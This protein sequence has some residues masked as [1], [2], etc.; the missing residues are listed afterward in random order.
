M[1][2]ERNIL[3]TYFE[4]G[5]FPTESQFAQLIDSYAHL[6]EFNFSLKAKP[7][8]ISKGKFYH[9]HVANNIK[10][11]GAGHKIIEAPSGSTPNSINGYT[12]VL[13]RNV[14]YK[15][16]DV[17][18][19][20]GIDVEKHKPMIIIERYKQRKKLRSGYV[21][22][23]GFYKERLEDAQLWNRKSEYIVTSLKTNIDLEPIHYFKPNS[24]Y[25]RFAPSGS[26]RRENSFQHTAHKKPF[27]PIQLR[28]QITIDGEMY[29][30][31]PV[32]LKIVLGSSGI[33]DSINFVFN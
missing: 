30:S 24:L 2:Q 21:K 1:K 7:S 32:G 22:P 14:L 4:T 20:G 9:F 19:I 25:K 6:N 28:L 18:I 15:T 27:V 13:S 10:D 23:A 29:T 31:L 8:G 16:L 12:H 26:V 17:E 3:K 5:D 11:S 33:D